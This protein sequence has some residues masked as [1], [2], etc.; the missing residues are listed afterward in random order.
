MAVTW[1]AGSSGKLIELRP[2]LSEGV[3]G[4]QKDFE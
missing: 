2:K 1:T 3:L 4:A